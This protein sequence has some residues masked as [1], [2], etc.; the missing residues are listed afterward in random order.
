MIWF[1]LL[2]LGSLFFVVDFLVFIV[3]VEVFLFFFRGVV[4]CGF[5]GRERIDFGI[6]FGW[7]LGVVLLV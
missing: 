6:G 4:M 2:F 1:W 3:V 7:F 5:R